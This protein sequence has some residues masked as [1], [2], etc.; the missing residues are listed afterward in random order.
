MLQLRNKTPLAAALAV[1]PDLRGVDSLILAV[2]ATFTLA[3][4][5]ALSDEQVPV[6]LADEIEAPEEIERSQKSEE[7]ERP[8][9]PSE[10]PG[11]LR[12]PCEL[13]LCRP[14]TDVVILG[15]AHAP[16][17]RAVEQHEA[18]VRVGAREVGLLVFGDREWTGAGSAATAP[19][20]FVQM[21]LTYRRAFGGTVRSESGVRCEERNPV[22]VGFTAEL[23]GEAL[24][25]RPLPNLEDPRSR[26]RAPGECP[27]PLGLGAIAPS[28]LP[29]RA[30]AGT[31]D[32]AWQ[33]S[34]A[35]FLP[36]DFDP[37]FLQVAHPELVQPG[38]LR[39]GEPVR[40]RGLRREGSL[41]FSLPEL[42]LSARVKVGT[43][44]LQPPLSLAQVLI[45]PDRGRLELLFDAAIPCPRGA[46]QV[47]EI[48]LD[49][50]TLRGAAA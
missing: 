44:L 38:R 28:W 23:R 31:Y 10:V 45:E 16:N 26:L 6:R 35:P 22:G 21:P 1:F 15:S 5:L 37:R 13:S 43:E 29:R 12:H 27:R 14:A 7:S 4:V 8:R 25:G 9:G 18:A 36:A 49:L 30:C 46:L 40:L 20:P 32:A 48:E 42:A 34:R 39:G 11:A 19:R 33:Q 2:K 50:Q 47:R 24:R 41:D 3:P 17:G